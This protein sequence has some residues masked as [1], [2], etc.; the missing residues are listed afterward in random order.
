MNPDAPPAS[1][2]SRGHSATGGG[3]PQD[4]AAGAGHDGGDSAPKP[5]SAAG[6]TAASVAPTMTEPAIEAPSSQTQSVAATPEIVTKVEMTTA[7]SAATTG[8][9]DGNGDVLE[10]VMGHPGL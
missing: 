2:G 10:V 6:A 4:S 1:Q 8:D 5:N 9:G 3:G 7:T